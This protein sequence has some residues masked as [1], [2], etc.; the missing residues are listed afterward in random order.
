M[1]T[2]IIFGSFGTGTLAGVIVA[3][4]VRTSTG[5]LLEQLRTRRSRDWQRKAME[6]QRKQTE[7]EHQVTTCPHHHCPLKNK[8]D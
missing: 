3:S 7:L 6:I 1:L 2:L 4:F 8:S 5:V